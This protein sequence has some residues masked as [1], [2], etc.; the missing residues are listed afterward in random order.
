MSMFK[1][2][3]DRLS[4]GKEVE[5]L[6]FTI[7]D[8]PAFLEDREKE[9]TRALSHETEKNRKAISSARSGLI[10]QI[11][12]LVS[13]EREEA[14][15]PKLEKIARNSLPLFE[16][17]MLSSLARTLP[18]EPEAFYHAASESLKGCVKGLAGPGRY[19]RGVFPDEMKEIR[20]TVDL[21]G[22][23][24][25]AMTPHIARARMKRD[26]VRALKKDLAWLTEALSE[27]ENLISGL[28]QT[29]AEIEVEKE[30][31][32]L[33]AGEEQEVRL[34]FTAPDIAILNQDANRLREEVLAEERVIRNNLSVISHLLRKGENVLQKGQGGAAAK[35]LELVGDSLT[36]SGLPAEEQ[37]IPG[38]VRV[39]PLIGSMIENGDIVLK[40]K[41]EKELFSGST[42]IVGS[43]SR[44]YRKLELTDSRLKAVEREIAE[45]PVV[46]RMRNLERE[47]VQRET[48][49]ASLT[50]RRS[51]IEERAALLNG[52]IPATLDRVEQALSSLEERKVTLHRPDQA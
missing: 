41:E 27:K 10:K 24:M 52:E 11:H 8:I 18:E 44:H 19:L 40:N 39:L 26:Q 13:L 46:I 1:F 35:D 45:N 43:L 21:I 15:H 49:L 7:M 2:L 51:G 31:L 33:L 28:S 3:R 47:K 30:G 48:R 5:P 22:R 25:N 38:L 12:E 32:T 34:A 36:V 37:V 14:Y 6:S 29:E 20:E 17:A 42:D 23:E 16:K 50:V 4:T 9:I